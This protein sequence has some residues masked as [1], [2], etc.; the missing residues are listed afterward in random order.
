MI[1]PKAALTPSTNGSRTIRRD[2]S[3]TV[4]LPFGNDGHSMSDTTLMPTLLSQSR[5]TRAKPKTVKKDGRILKAS[6]SGILESTRRLNSTT[7]MTFL[8]LSFYGKD[9]T[10]TPSPAKHDYLLPLSRTTD[11]HCPSVDMHSAYR[12]I[13]IWTEAVFTRCRFRL[14]ADFGISTPTLPISVS[15][16]YVPVV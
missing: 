2:G 14:R 1:R 4:G 10:Q 16:E 13:S 11:Y 6:D 3:K 12:R 5:T 9:G 8:L 7:R 15:R